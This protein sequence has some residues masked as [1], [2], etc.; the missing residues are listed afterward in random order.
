MAQNDANFRR[1]LLYENTEFLHQLLQGDVFVQLKI[2]R[3]AVS[4]CNLKFQNE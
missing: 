4:I 3:S 2:Y 1:L